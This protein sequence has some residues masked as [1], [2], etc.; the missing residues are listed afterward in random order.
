VHPDNKS[1]DSHLVHN[2]FQTLPVLPN[3]WR[4]SLEWL[5][6]LKLVPPPFMNPLGESALAK[7]NSQCSQH[8]GT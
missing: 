2:T 1:A 5:S 7:P 4:H 8:M 3:H 6:T